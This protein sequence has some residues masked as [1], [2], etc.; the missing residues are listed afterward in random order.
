MMVEHYNELRKTVTKL[1]APYK[2]ILAADEST[3]T[4]GKRFAQINLEN[5]HENRFAYRDMVFRTPNL[6]KHISGVITYEETLFDTNSDGSH[7]VQPLLDSG[8]VVGIK[9]DCGLSKDLL[10]TEN[11]TRGIDSLAERSKKF[12]DAGARFAKFRCVFDLN[13]T[14]GTPSENA[15]H[16]NANILA[17]YAKISIQNGLVPI[18]EPEVLME[19]FD[20][21]EASEMI[22]RRVLTE[23]YYRM[24]LLEIPLECT[25]LKPNMVRN[26]KNCTNPWSTYDIA[27]A[28]VRVL[29]STVPPS[30]PGIFFLSG[31]M[32]EKDATEALKFINDD[33]SLPWR[34]SFSYGRALQQSA[35]QEWG[36]LSKNERKAQATLF[37]R[38]EENGL[39]SMGDTS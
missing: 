4:I 1:C 34:V 10:L 36:G 8:I 17:N 31:G 22:T 16:E 37:R 32:T 2:G 18:V 11:T 12:Y 9:T 15:I 19:N 25:V 27:D 13:T 35:I 14:N 7:L 39:A 26:S 28:T 29:K 38:S 30:V 23:V 20:N 21:I 33:R 5:T 6:S 24:N 3:G